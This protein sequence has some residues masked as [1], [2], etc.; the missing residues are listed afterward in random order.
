[1]RIKTITLSRRSFNIELMI[2]FS[3]QRVSR[4]IRKKMKRRKIRIRKKKFQKKT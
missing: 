4:R 3:L 2:T 1:M